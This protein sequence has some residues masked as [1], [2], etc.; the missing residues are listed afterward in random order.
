MKHY[1]FFNEA[2]NIVLST[3]RPLKTELVSVKNSLFR[4]I[5]QDIK[6]KYDIPN[7]NN[8]AM[9]GFAVRSKD[10]LTATKTS[11]VSLKIIGTMPAGRKLN[12]KIRYCKDKPCI[13]IMTGSP[14]PKGFDA[15]IEKE[16][17]IEENGYIKV[18]SPV[19][20]FHNIRFHGEDVVRGE[21][22]IKKG[23]LITA[24]ELGMIIS[25]GYKNVKVYTQPRVAIIATGDE[26]VEIEE[27]ISFGKVKN[28][29]SYT[30]SALVEKNY[31]I[32]LNL[33]IARDN[34]Y[35]LKRKIKK[36]LDIADMV[37]ISGGVS[38]GEYDLVKPVLQ[39]LGA[40]PHFWEIRE[41]PGK[42]VFFATF[43]HKYIFGVPGNVVSNMVVFE[44]LIKPALLKLSGRGQFI[45][46]PLYDAILKEPIKKKTGLRY[47]IRGMC[48]YKD[49]KFYVRT[50]GPQG[51]GILKSMLL[52]NCII[53]LDEKTGSLSKG[54]VVKIKL[55]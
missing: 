41:R 40:E 16:A 34:F 35:M 31:C 11:P 8:S 24:A 21:T 38:H 3:I 48:E 23:K 51:S 54:D 27:K 1:I 50:T 29:N 4:V 28:V 30:L 45:D 13:S 46:E 49:S 26:L 20:K 36:G 43:N 37:L 39:S 10:T 32:P 9:D 25:C 14:L 5:A 6:S 12:K 55:I 42:P 15:V 52:A 19:E 44:M 33:G 17:V 18:F 2:K 7:Y 53:I 22:V 47:F